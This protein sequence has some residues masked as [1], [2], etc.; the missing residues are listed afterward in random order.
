MRNN[1]RKKMSLICLLFCMILLAG[2]PAAAKTK[3]KK[4][5]VFAKVTDVKISKKNVKAGDTLRYSF[6]IKA[7]KITAYNECKYGVDNVYL[8]WKS[9][10][11]PKQ[12]IKMNIPWDKAG[13]K[14]K[15]NL[16]VKG[17]IKIKKRMTG[18]NWKLTGIYFNY[19]DPESD[20]GNNSLYLVH[21]KGANYKKIS[22]NKL[23]VDLSETRFKVKNKKVDADKD[24]PVVE[25]SSLELATESPLKGGVF[26]VRVTD[27]SQIKSVQ[28]VWENRTIEEGI[29]YRDD[30]EKYT[31]NYNKKTGYY[32]CDIPAAVKDSV[33][34]ESMFKQLTSIKVVDAYGNQAEYYTYGQNHDKKIEASKLILYS[35][36]EIQKQVEANPDVRY[37]TYILER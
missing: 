11:T 19:Q 13:A 1:V 18:G 24:A 23:A 16:R 10:K 14:H 8:I 9:E 12:E 35:D 29:R 2:V 31:M 33:T 4:P 5:K 28:C 36:A 30:Y 26:R 7:P 37:K 20:D 32:E 27:K 3:V 22:K 6:V 34:K 15:P 21:K 25:E 17:K